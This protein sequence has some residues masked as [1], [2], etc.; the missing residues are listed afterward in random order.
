M[1]SK[2]IFR[3]NT[4]LNHLNKDLINATDDYY[5]GNPEWSDRSRSDILLIPKYLGGGLPHIIIEVQQQVD[6]MFMRRAISY[7]LQGYKRY[8][9][10]PIALIFCVEKLA[11]D[12]KE[13]TTTSRIKGAYSFPCQP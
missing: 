8:Q 6:I 5:H 1:V 3:D 11:A 2:E 4:I 10:D 9:V 7:A 13:M 12:V